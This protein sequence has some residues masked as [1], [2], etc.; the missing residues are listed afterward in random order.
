MILDLVILFVLVIS[1]IIGFKIGFF[2]YVL[3]IA[4]LLSGFIISLLLTTPCTNLV[5]MTPLGSSIVDSIMINLT[6]SGIDVS[7]ATPLEDLLVAAGVPSFLTGIITQFFGNPEQ[8]ELLLNIA[9]KLGSMIISLFVFFILLIF[10]T[11]II[12]ILKKFVDALRENA[13]FRVFDGILGVGFSALIY[14]GVLYLVIAIVIGL[15][16]IN[17][18][19][20]QIT[21]F[22]DTQLDSKI[23]IFSYFYNNNIVINL[24][25]FIIGIF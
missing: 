18:I 4:S 9:T 20:T 14:L 21:P 10:A 8:D 7:S 3:K 2:K 13:G 1:I 17:I 6:N 12:F 24:I 16:G 25:D 5:M 11:I 19:S 15:Q 23:G 22:I